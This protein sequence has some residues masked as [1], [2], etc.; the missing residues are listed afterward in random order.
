ME[1]I[2]AKTRQRGASSLT[3]LFMIFCVAALITVGVKVGPLYMDNMSI[4]QAIASAG[5][6]NFHNMSK[7]EIRETLG[8][9]FRVNGVS[10]NPK[11]IKIEKNQNSTVLN[12]FHEERVNIFS[13]VDVVVSFTNTYDTADQ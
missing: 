7:D 8:K 2:T 6:R 9:T 4:D 5:S 1:N 13:N 10:V 3:I 12:Y 11:N